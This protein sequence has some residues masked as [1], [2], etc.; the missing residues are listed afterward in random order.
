[1][2][3]G[4]SPM[5]MPLACWGCAVLLGAHALKGQ[6]RRVHKSI[7]SHRV[8]ACQAASPYGSAQV[9]EVASLHLQ[10]SMEGNSVPAPAEKLPVPPPPLAKA[11]TLL[12]AVFEAVPEACTPASPRLRAAP[13]LLVG[14][15][16]RA[17]RRSSTRRAARHTARTARRAV[18]AWLRPTPP[19]QQPLVPSYDASRLRTKLQVG[20]R[21]VTHTRSERSRETRTP[22]MSMGFGGDNSAVLLATNF[23]MS[24]GH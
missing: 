7:A 9:H 1:M 20:L 12:Q 14:G 6:R 21:L 11:E 8:L 24:E 3:M 19:P 23:D 16:R 5:A 13:A 22:S 4:V 15:A 10:R 17:C 18:G 2:Q